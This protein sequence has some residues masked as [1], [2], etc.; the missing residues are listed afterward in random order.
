M[1]F[2]L[3][4]G[5]RADDVINDIWELMIGNNESIQNTCMCKLGCPTK[6]KRRQ[7]H[8]T[9][10]GTYFSFHLLEKAKTSVFKK[11]KKNIS[12]KRMFE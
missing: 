1:I 7:Q 2:L 9:H 6:K 4:E 3:V 11:K 8:C 5:G 10:R 12:K